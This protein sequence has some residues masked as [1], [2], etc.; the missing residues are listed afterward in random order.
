[1]V[2]IPRVDIFNNYVY[3]GKHEI[4]RFSIIGYG[5]NCVNIYTFDYIHLVPLDT[6]KRLILF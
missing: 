2:C 4:Q 1:M 6:V 5:I 3:A